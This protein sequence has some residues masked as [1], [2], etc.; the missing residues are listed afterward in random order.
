MGITAVQ[1]IYDGVEGSL[2]Q[3]LV[4]SYTQKYRV[5]T[6]SSDTQ[7]VSVRNATDPNTGLRIPLLFDRYM[8]GTD[9]DLAAMATSIS[10]SAGDMLASGGAVWEVTV[11]YSTDVGEDPQ[12]GDNPLLRPPVV[13]WSSEN[14]I[15]IVDKDVND[16]PIVNTANKPFDPGVDI[17]EARFI[18]E[19][20]RNEPIFNT[21]Y[22][23]TY[24]NAINS[25][26]FLGFAPGTARIT[27]IRAQQ[28][29]ENDVQFWQISLQITFNRDGWQKKILNAGYEKKL[30]ANPVDEEDWEIIKDVTGARLSTPSNLSL[31][32]QS[33]LPDGTGIFLTFDVYEEVPFG[34][35]GL[36]L[37]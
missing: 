21:A 18:L 13:T 19:V 1:L 34:P 16:E 36:T 2:D 29:V 27:G 10:C 15:R 33:V 14:V 25:D 20:Q 24:Q 26:T 3:K 22:V 9:Q 35:L 28:L 37:G 17:E 5:I 31:N 23:D 30:I 11:Q 32:G 4:R 7:S 12:Q 8:P 6:D